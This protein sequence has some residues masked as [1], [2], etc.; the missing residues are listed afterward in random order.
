MQEYGP[1][2]FFVVITDNAANEKRST[3]LL[4]GKFDHIVPLGCLS[5]TLN[6]LIQDIIKIDSTDKTIKRI[7][8]IVKNVKKSHVL[9]AAF[10]KEKT[11]P[12]SLSL[13]VSTRWGSHLKTLDDFLKA[14]ST[15]QKLAV[16]EN[17]SELLSKENKTKILD[18]DIFLIQ[19]TNIAELIRPIVQW[20]YKLES[21]EP[22]IHEVVYAFK[23]IELALAEKIP[24]SP[25]TSKE[26]QTVMEKFQSRKQYALQPIHFAATI[27][28]PKDQ[29]CKLTSEEIL[30]A[31]NFIDKTASNMT[32]I[33]PVTVLSSLTNYR[34][35][36]NGWSMEI[37]W[38]TV[39][40]L[41]PLSWWKGVGSIICK[42]LSKVAVRIL[43]MPTSSAST[44]RSFSTF[45]RVHGKLRN[46][47]TTQRA[48]KLSFIS[49]N[50]RLLNRD[51]DT[52]NRKISSIEA[53]CGN[54][55]S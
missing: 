25:L 46:R 6:L 23:E 44:E 51:T 47:L 9:T 38:K 4:K 32:D 1:E 48:V 2:K 28:N 17:T 40:T 21:D 13:P 39:D 54:G 20:I 5:H 34:N 35:K 15:L 22:I 30:I 43:S 3:T 45:G 50:Y 42:Q 52:E 16:G 49:H 26:E 36:D 18:N 11:A 41:S 8:D 53:K 33:N 19:V 29:G 14:K 7:A 27:L 10:N 55:K 12:I 24:I 37:I 31:M